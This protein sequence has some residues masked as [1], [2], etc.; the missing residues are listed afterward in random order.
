[1][2]PTGCLA[3]DGISNPTI[4]STCGAGTPG[5]RPRR[6]S[7][8]GGEGG[9]PCDMLHDIAADDEDEAFI[10]AAL[11]W[12][13]PCDGTKDGGRTGG[14]GAVMSVIPVSHITGIR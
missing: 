6:D 8:D 9:A 3:T 2:L 10:V 12:D 1:M 5:G 14:E 4:I 11:V 13:T 7:K